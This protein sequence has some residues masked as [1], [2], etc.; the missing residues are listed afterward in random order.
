MA[1][2]S[3]E[4]KITP[5]KEKMNKSQ[6][7]AHFADIALELL[8]D[9]GVDLDERKLERLA[10]KLGTEFLQGFEDLML[11]HLVKGGLGSFTLPGMFTAK[12]VYKPA[13]KGGKEQP[14]PF[15]PGEMMIT[16]DKPASVRVKI[17][18]MKK[19]KEAAEAGVA[20]HRRLAKEALAKKA[21]RAAEKEAAEKKTKKKKSSKK[22]LEKVNKKSSKKKSSLRDAASKSSKKL[23]KKKKKKSTR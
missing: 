11:G 23:D 12:G 21:E 7:N 10:K 18:G 17:N 4:T 2:K 14:N 6:L 1:K 15:K 22:T 5:I 13:V 20:T 3:K 9:A 19:M 8:E 16:K